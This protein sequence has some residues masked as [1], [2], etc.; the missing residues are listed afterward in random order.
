MLNEN[1][2]ERVGRFYFKFSNIEELTILET[3]ISCTVR[4]QMK[5]YQNVTVE[6]FI[7]R[8]LYHITL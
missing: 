8:K 5:G 3:Y 4:L 6:E 1:A 2:Q 7:G